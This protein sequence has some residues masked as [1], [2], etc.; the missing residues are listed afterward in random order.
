MKLRSET[1]IPTLG[2]SFAAFEIERSFGGVE[3]CN[4]GLARVGRV[5]LGL[6]RVGHGG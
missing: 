4:H 3:R 5:A 6:A 1:N 2:I